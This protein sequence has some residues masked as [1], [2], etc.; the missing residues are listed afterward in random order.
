LQHPPA[1]P[2]KT[3]ATTIDDFSVV[4]FGVLKFRNAWKR[5]CRS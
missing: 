1:R 4:P 3:A 2:A 5:T